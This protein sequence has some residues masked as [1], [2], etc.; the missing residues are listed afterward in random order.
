MEVDNA[1][2]FDFINFEID[3]RASTRILHYLERT[4]ILF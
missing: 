2:I 3:Q 4:L 1:F